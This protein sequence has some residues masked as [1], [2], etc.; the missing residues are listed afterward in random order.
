[1]KLN[2]IILLLLIV[3]TSCG[4][5]TPSSETSFLSTS[6]SSSLSTSLVSSVSPVSITP[7]SFSSV[8]SSETTSSSQNII[9]GISR[10]LFNFVTDLPDTDSFLP[11]F[12]TYETYQTSQIVDNLDYYAGPI[13]KA[14]LPP[15]YFGAQL[16]QLRSQIGF[17]DGL[18]EN[19]TTMLSRAASL[20]ELYNTYL[21]N[22]PGNPFAYSV[23]LG[24][25]SFAIT[26]LENELVIKVVV[27][28]ANVTMAVLNVNGQI[29]YWIDVYITDNNRVIVYRTPT[30]L[31][32]L[33]NVLISAVRVSY[34]LEII[35]EG[36]N[37]RGFSY[38]RYGTES[39][40][41]KNYVVFKSEGNYFIVA[42]ERGDFILGA[43]PK[44]N[45][46]TYEMTSGKYLGS[47]V[48]ETIP[49]TGPT[50]ETI[51]YPMWSLA[52]WTSI[53][54]EVDNDDD[55]EFPQVYLNGLNTPLNVHYNSL[56]G[57]TTSRKYDIELKRSYVY[58]EVSSGVW[59]KKQFFYPAFF[60]QQNEV[61]TIA[62][63][64]TANSRNG[65]VFSHTL[66]STQ[67]AAIRAYYEAMK[68]EQSAYKQVDVDGYIITLLAEIA[69]KN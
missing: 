13:N 36:N 42:G 24:G 50:Y 65:N 63:F 9:V 23:E 44:V 46:E 16:D 37:V 33:G 8:A 52:G 32:I 43:S 11:S 35:K 54:F 60:I 29:T 31:L 51:W 6:S 53:Q 69:Q 58:V 3:I 19:L 56:F 21:S 47:Q 41:L 22:N 4:G 48:L 61:S 7:S 55:K 12:L 20:G 14:N 25:F 49:I 68:N 57:I 64:G 1:M 27:G 2:K 17:M 66:N 15:T 26:G 39:T 67:L 10:A 45:V 59:E 18:T 5:A 38:E 62:P 34:L 28:S 30:K 40:A